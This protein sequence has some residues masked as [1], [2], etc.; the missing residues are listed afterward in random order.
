MISRSHISQQFQDVV[1]IVAVLHH[2]R[3]DSEPGV[4]TNGI[5]VENHEG[6]NR[7]CFIWIRLHHRNLGE[8]GYQTLLLEDP[9][10]YK[11]CPLEE[12]ASHHLSSSVDEA[13]AYYVDYYNNQ[14]MAAWGPKL[15]ERGI[16]SVTFSAAELASFKEQA[17]G[18]VHSA[19][20]T[21]MNDRGLPA[22][23]LYDLVL[24]TLAK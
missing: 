9:L 1:K 3:S 18:P 2:Q 13:L 14:T 15:T 11:N 7:E 6:K 4:D 16:E 17:A 22:Q 5:Y 24:S 21:K 19:W 8:K 10:I 23:E 20:I 12:S